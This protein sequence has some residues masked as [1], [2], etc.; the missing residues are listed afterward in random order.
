MVD[1]QHSQNPTESEWTEMQT[2]KLAEIL[3]AAGFAKNEQFF[4]EVDYEGPFI[5]FGECVAQWP[6]GKVQ[7]QMWCE[8]CDEHKRKSNELATA[9]WLTTHSCQ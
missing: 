7:W 1:T 4:V 5:R 2:E 6:L 9:L 8:E 3:S